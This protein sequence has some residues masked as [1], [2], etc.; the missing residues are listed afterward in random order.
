ML[1]HTMKIETVFPNIVIRKWQKLVDLL[2]ATFD[3][4]ATL[5]THVQDDFLKILASSITEGNPYQ[6]GEYEG[7]PIR[8]VKLLLRII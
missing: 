1:N 3:L 5:V 7:L 4:P 2:S 6:S 8:I